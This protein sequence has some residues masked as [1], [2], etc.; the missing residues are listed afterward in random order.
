MEK[1]FSVE[2]KVAV[3]TGGS[4][5]IGFMIA[6][7]YAEAGARVYIT[8]RKPAELH[9]AAEEIAKVGSC[10]AV[11]TDLATEEGAKKLAAAV[12][13]QEEGIDI[14]INNAGATWGAPFPEFPAAGW[15]RVLDLN[16]KAPFFVFRALYPLL[17][18]NA[19][20]EDP[21]RVI[22]IGSIAGFC[23]GGLAFSYGASKAA[24]HQMTQN[25]AHQFAP[26]RITVNCIAPG[27]F[28]SKMLQ[29]ITEDED[30]L[31]DLES[32]I[33]LG[34][35]G[36]PQDMV[37]LAL[38]L[39]SRAGAWMTGAVIPLDGG[40]RLVSGLN[41]SSLAIKQYEVSK[42]RRAGHGTE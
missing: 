3:V 25:W 41:G 37:G 26:E 19:S 28:P 32:R 24:I 16:V 23:T 36:D 22:N 10:V 31:A 17:K 5:G 9:A 7:G 27:T 11:Q 12:A 20:H 29:Y 2:G 42:Q 40:F 8:A 21:S 1:L 30:A 38:F 18:K 13:E 33:P 6:K 39:A 34:R 4:R 35:M 14:L 15:D